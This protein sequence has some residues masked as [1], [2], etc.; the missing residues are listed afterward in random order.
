MASKIRKT[1]K[2]AANEASR[3]RKKGYNAH[4][5]GAKSPFKVVYSKRK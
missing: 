4:V 5:S 1:Y 2:G 3:M